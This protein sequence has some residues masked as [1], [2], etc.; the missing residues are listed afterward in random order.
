MKDPTIIME[1]LKHDKVKLVGDLIDRF[2][3]LKQEYSGAF[4]NAYEFAEMLLDKS[5]E[6]DVAHFE[7][8]NKVRKDN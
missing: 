2:L 7:A 4:W 6:L 8:R 5:Q 1:A 3:E